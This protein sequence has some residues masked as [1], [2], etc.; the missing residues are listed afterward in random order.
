[1]EYLTKCTS[2]ESTIK[3][4]WKM[5]QKAP[6]MVKNVTQSIIK[7]IQ[8]LRRTYYSINMLRYYC[9]S[10]CKYLC[11]GGCTLTNT[12]FEGDNRPLIGTKMHCALKNY[13]SILSFFT[14]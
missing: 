12:G 10:Q 11:T 5:G 8:R 7:L 2:A 6:P 4:V 13:N 14:V 3:D 1:M 9:A